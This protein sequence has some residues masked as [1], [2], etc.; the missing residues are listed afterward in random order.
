MQFS[1]QAHRKTSRT[2]VKL[3]TGT[4]VDFLSITYKHIHLFEHISVFPVAGYAIHKNQQKVNLCIS[5]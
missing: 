4:A 2:V 1:M 3:Q 5:V